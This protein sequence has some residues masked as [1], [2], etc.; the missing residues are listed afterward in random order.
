MRINTC[1]FTFELNGAYNIIR[2]VFPKAFA[3]GIEGVAVHPLRVT[4]V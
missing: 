3:E 2:K 4:L 1:E